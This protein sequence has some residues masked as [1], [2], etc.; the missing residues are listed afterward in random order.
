MNGSN[1]KHRQRPAYGRPA[2]A[3]ALALDRWPY[4]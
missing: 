3:I 1:H 2:L 4:A